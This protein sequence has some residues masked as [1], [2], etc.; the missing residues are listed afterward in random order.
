MDVGSV[1]DGERLSSVSD[2]DR[3]SPMTVVR[4]CAGNIRSI[5]FPVQPLYAEQEA[6]VSIIVLAH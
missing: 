2:S 3:V 1:P 4:I 6:P 5:H